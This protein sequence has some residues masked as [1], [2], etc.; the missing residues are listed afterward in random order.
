M[1]LT[2]HV[3]LSGFEIGGLTVSWQEELRKLDEELASGRLSADDYRVRRD[4]VLSSA[5]T[6][7][8]NPAEGQQAQPQQVQPQQAQ[9]QQAQPQQPQQ[10]QPDQSADSSANSTQI[11]SPASL[12]QG[13]PQPNQQDPNFGGAERT[14]VVSA[15]QAQ[16][17][18]QQPQQP[19]QPQ[20]GYPQQSGLASPAGGFQQ[21]APMSPAGGFQQPGQPW[22]AAEA[23]QSP[24][25][26]GSE[27]PPLTP[28]TQQEESGQGPETFE[29][30]SGSRKKVIGIVAAVVLVAALG[31][32]AW[33]LFFNGSDDDAVADPTTQQ[34]TPS[35]PP[36]TPQP[37]DDLAIA[38]LPGT[39]DERPDVTTFEA[40][41]AGKV[42]TD[43]ENEVLEEAGAGDARMAVAE[44]PSGDRAVVLTVEVGSESDAADAV[45]G[46]VE[47]QDKYG[48]E[49]YNG[50]IAAEGVQANELDK[51]EEA[52]ALTRA[53]YAHGT[54]VVRIQVTA[55][56]L[57][58]LRKVFEE[59]VA[60]QLQALPADG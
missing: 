17:A 47:L 49:D 6:S 45:D 38:S 8:E 58:E 51:K 18:P 28:P 4:Q 50:D 20:P 14:Q 59:I 34:P 26:G 5:V 55:P 39:V 2:G 9:P 46:L 37:P 52:P 11:I 16:Q 19:Q 32:G 40:V 13:T 41:V 56:E 33:L 24:P 10:P 44:L 35:A 31:V 53:H 12:P 54:T 27:F 60:L 7:G 3:S 57:S 21:P 48:L 42:L 15:W 23:D 36:S 30:S 1:V 29:T 25:W 43:E 22:N